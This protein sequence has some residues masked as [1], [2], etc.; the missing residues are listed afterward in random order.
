MEKTRDIEVERRLNKAL[1]DFKENVYRVL[2][3]C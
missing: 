1:F 3:K 2:E